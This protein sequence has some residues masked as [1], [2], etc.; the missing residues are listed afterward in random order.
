VFSSLGSCARDRLHLCFPNTNHVASVSQR[1]YL[2]G[3]GGCSSNS[4][5]SGGLLC[6][7]FGSS[8]SNSTCDGIPD[9]YFDADPVT[10]TLVFAKTLRRH[11]RAFDRHHRT[12]LL[13][14]R[15][16]TSCKL[17]GPSSA[18]AA[19]SGLEW[20]WYIWSR[21]SKSRSKKESL[22]TFLSRGAAFGGGDVAA[23]PTLGEGQPVEG[24]EA[25]G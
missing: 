13:R 17:Y 10:G 9:S 23:L 11:R 24:E 22:V 12:R 2:L 16:F 7:L 14:S 4:F 3:S 5:S 21:I 18:E 8:S 1:S 19:A 15:H 25:R 20:E 6:S